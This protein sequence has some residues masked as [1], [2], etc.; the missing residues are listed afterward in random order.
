MSPKPQLSYMHVA[1]HGKC[2]R[3][4]SAYLDGLAVV[5]DNESLSISSGFW[6]GL[7]ASAS[8]LCG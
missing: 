2:P 6:C 4:G 5:K 7:V 1:F 3:F 8:K